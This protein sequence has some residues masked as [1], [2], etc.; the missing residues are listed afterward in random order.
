M[1]V[2]DTESGREGSLVSSWADNE[3]SI[4]RPP[5]ESSTCSMALTA[6][7]KYWYIVTIN[8]AAE[9][10]LGWKRVIAVTGICY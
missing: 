10:Y 9:L 3:R 1:T 4:N 8:M 7:I 5:I 6:V 2:T